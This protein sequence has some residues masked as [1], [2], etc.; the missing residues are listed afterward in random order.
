[1]SQHET[2]TIRVPGSTSNCGAGFDTLGM[3]VNVSNTVRVTRLADGAEPKPER[4]SDSRAQDMVEA[5]AALYFKTTGE[6]T[7]GFAY[8]I[9]GEVPAARGLGSSVTVRAGIIAALDALAET[10]LSRKE[11]VALVTELE[12]HPDNAAA[13]VLG[14]FCVARSDPETGAYIDTV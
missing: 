3:A 2:V 7:I 1:M 10:K 4:E 12:G 13:S 9:D 6:A 14:G 11:I 8:Q 5:A